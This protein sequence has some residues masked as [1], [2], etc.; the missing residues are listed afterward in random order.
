MDPGVAGAQGP[1][2]F[3]RPGT[4][5]LAATSAAVAEQLVQRPVRAAFDL[6]AIVERPAP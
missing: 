1:P 4:A 6:A 2:R 3:L 5:G